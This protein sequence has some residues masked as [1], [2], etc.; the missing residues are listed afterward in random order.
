LVFLPVRVN[1]SKPYSFVLDSG[2]STCAI[3]RARARELGLAFEDGGKAIGVGNGTFK[4]D[5]ARDISLR[6]PGVTLSVE[7]LAVMD[8]SAFH[9]VFGRPVDGV[10]GF[11]IFE[12]FIV[13]IDHDKRTV[14]FFDPQAYRDL[15][16]GEKLP[17]DIEHKVPSISLTL[18][19]SGQAAVERRVIVDTGLASAFVDDFIEKTTSRKLQVIG[20]V[21]LGEE[22]KAIAAR[23]EALELGSIVIEN[24]IGRTG[25]PIIGGE[26]LTRFDL[27]FDYTHRNLILKPNRRFREP[28]LYDASGLVLRLAPDA[29][30]FRVH[31]VL[32]ESPAAEAGLR[33]GDMLA[34]I[35]GR[36]AADHSLDEVQRLLKQSGKSHEL[37]VRRGD[38]KF[39]VTLKLRKL[40]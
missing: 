22:T 18:K 36:Q 13:A 34:A 17:L 4:V 33:R 20:G 28:Y 39:T 15:G 30:L 31:A 9:S 7:R 5:I 21:G 1:G 10:L 3:D 19:V 26:I 11:E 38:Q 25:K 2:A 14:S 23:V 35:D 27:V 32:E 37:H 40:L 12:H 8:F 6:L 29:K 16:Q 24:P